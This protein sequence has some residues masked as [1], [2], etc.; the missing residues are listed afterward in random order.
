MIFSKITIRPFFDDDE[1]Q[2]LNLW[3]RV[4]PH[5]PPQNNPVRDLK[6]RRE[7]ASGLFL[8]ALM[9]DRMVGVVVASLDDGSGWVHYLGV[10]PEFRREG[11]ATALMRRL[12]AQLIGKGCRELALQIQ[13]END[14]VQ[15]FY[16]SLRY[17]QKDSLMMVKKF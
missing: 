16:E 2:L 10:D 6:T 13:A 9:D 4:Y 8:V 1:N 11:I 12:E 14:D 15:A 7:A 17:D 5:A 3:E